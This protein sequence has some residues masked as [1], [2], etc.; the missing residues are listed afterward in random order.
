MSP[1]AQRTPL[2]LGLFGLPSLLLLLLDL[3]PARGDCNAPERLHFAVLT[4]DSAA[5]QSFP[6]G[7]EVKYTCRPGYQ[8]NFKF[9]PTRTCLPDGT[10]SKANEFCQKK[11]CP[12]LGELTNGH[13]KI[14]NDILFG[15]TVSFICDEGYVLIGE[16][17]SR[18]EIVEGNKV[19]WSE[20]LP[21][22]EAIRCD[23]PPVI[24]NGQHTGINQD[25]FTYGSV[26]RYRCD[27][28][29]SLIGNEVIHCTTENMKDG[30]WSDP[31]PECKVVRCE[32]PL[33]PNGYIQSL[34]RSSY[35]YKETVI[36]ECNPGFNMIGKE[37]ISCGANNTWIPDIPQCIKDVKPTTVGATTSTTTTTS[38]SSSTGGS[39][40]ST[41]GS[42]S[43]TGGSSSSTGGSSSSTS[44]SSSFANKKE[45]QLIT[46]FL[47][48]P[49]VIFTQTGSFSFRNWL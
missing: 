13:I 4:G 25:F 15:S 14:E 10:W 30:I 47:V 49:L 9:P 8:R 32:T 22:C 36:L 44:G 19:G 35:T 27:A 38:S 46:V 29:Y 20:R 33:L 16:S 34:R 18:C 17:Q 43:S 21:V 31:P 40:S 3:T 37:M 48:I 6:E 28:T 2:A 1:A 5:Q 24:D 26:V 11:Q 23:L 7:S 45:N 41:G 12:N 39:S 42:S